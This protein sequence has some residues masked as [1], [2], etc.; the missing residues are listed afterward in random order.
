MSEKTITISLEDMLKGH[1]RLDDKA[2]AQSNERI[3]KIMKAV[4]RDFKKKQRASWEIASK[5]ILNA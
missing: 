2:V 1:P 5:T 4:V 3:S